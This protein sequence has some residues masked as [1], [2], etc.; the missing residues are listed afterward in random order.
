MSLR[1]I[2]LFLSCG[3]FCAAA[4]GPALA[5]NPPV[6]F[7]VLKVNPRF[8]G[9][10]V[11]LFTAVRSRNEWR[12]LRSRLISSYQRGQ[13]PNDLPWASGIDFRRYTMVV[14]AL[15]IRPNNGYNVVHKRCLRRHFKHRS[16]RDRI[17]AGS[18][19]RRGPGSDS[20]HDNCAYP[21]VH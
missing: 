14:A 17:G 9:T 12:S 13:V 7:E 16:R 19:L 10:N 1:R 8:S 20:P 11:P 3:P 6:A 2:L 18:R 21:S 4:I 5:S 15:G